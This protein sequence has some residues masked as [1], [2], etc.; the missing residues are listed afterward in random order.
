MF[1][2]KMESGMYER[3]IEGV[4][5][6][7]I[8][9]GMALKRQRER[10]RERAREKRERE[11]E[12]AA[13]CSWWSWSWIMI[14]Y[15]REW[16]S[17]WH[18]WWRTSQNTI[19]TG[20]SD[21]QMDKIQPF[22]IH[23]HPK[24]LVDLALPHTALYTSYAQVIPFV[25]GSSLPVHKRQKSFANAAEIEKAARR[26]YGD[27]QVSNT[28]EQLGVS[29]CLNRTETMRNLHSHVSDVSPVVTHCSPCSGG[30]THANWCYLYCRARTAS[31]HTNAS[32]TM[33]A[34]FV[35][36]VLGLKGMEG[37][38]LMGLFYP[39]REVD[40]KR[41]RW[42]IWWF[43][44]VLMC[45]QH[46][47]RNPWDPGVLCEDERLACCWH[48]NCRSCLANAC[49]FCWHLA[50]LGLHPFLACWVIMQI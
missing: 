43:A 47:V 23:V 18:A 3:A 30:I 36:G 41:C 32:Q 25:F 48:Q 38:K 20:Q 50:Y 27:S 22:L 12:H 39:T 10:E 15:L 24:L 14:W 44:D 34:E 29:I 17:R 40:L 37:K 7:N 5:M 1:L 8:S 6:D 2:L 31:C 21:R 9:I 33:G 19:R 4:D 49:R 42:V 16:L 26:G 28:K 46:L 35:K 45:W 13:F 11:R